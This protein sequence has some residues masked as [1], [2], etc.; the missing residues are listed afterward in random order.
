[1]SI[2]V[3]W[4]EAG[5]ICRHAILNNK[6]DTFHRIIHEKVSDADCFDSIT[7]YFLDN[8]DEEIIHEYNARSTH[9]AGDIEA[10]WERNITVD[11]INKQIEFET[12]MLYDNYKLENDD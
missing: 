5:L 2:S 3:T 11:Y 10:F 9:L 4:L 7:D 6:W 1:M 8:C 12:D